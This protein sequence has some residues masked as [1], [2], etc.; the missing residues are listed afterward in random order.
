MVM[1]M[2]G[3]SE[4]EQPRAGGQHR[5]VQVYSTLLRPLMKVRCDASQPG[6]RLG[7]DWAPAPAASGLPYELPRLI[8]E[9]P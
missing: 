3:F 9:F 1:D 2:A 8:T 6:R 7:A 5:A 4:I